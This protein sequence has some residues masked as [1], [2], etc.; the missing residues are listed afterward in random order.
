MN[1]IKK[2]K[3]ID[4]PKEKESDF[5]HERNTFAQLGSHNLITVKSD[6]MIERANGWQGR[7]KVAGINA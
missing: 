6:N 3:R 4:C 2:N 7:G 5:H 1:E